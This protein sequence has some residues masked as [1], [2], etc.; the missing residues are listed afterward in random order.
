MQMHDALG[1]QGCLVETSGVD[2]STANSGTAAHA[3][4][5]A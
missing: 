5:S 2:Q 3:K 4:I 1:A